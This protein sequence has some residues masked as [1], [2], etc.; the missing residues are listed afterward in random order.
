MRKDSGGATY[1]SAR[2]SSRQGIRRASRSSELTKLVC[3]T[4]ANVLAVR[5]E[6]RLL[7]W[8]LPGRRIFSV[9]KKD[10]DKAELRAKKAR[11]ARVADK[12]K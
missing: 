5:S 2:V 11:E 10:V 9:P 12:R 1:P 3:H 6:I 7:G 8:D 4:G